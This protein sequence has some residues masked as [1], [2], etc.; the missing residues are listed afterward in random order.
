[1]ADDQ[2]PDFDKSD[3]TVEPYQRRVDKPWGWEYHLVPPETPYMFKIIHINAGAR[4]SEQIHDEKRETW[5]LVN[6]QANVEWE[7]KDGNPVVTEL[8]LNVGF[9][10]Q[11]GQ[12][13]RLV[14]VTDCDV[15]EA[16]TPESGTTYRTADDYA[17]PDETPEQRAIERGE[18]A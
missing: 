11:I 10:T 17:R 7:D 9:S 14:G 18:A 2:V 5:T 6:G 1:M 3:F 16:S 12:K 8:K 13:H 4:L 15:A